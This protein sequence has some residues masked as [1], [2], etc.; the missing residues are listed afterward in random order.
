MTYQFH[1]DIQPFPTSSG[2]CLNSNSILLLSLFGSLLIFSKHLLLASISKLSVFVPSNLLYHQHGIHTRS[3][4][5]RSGSKHPPGQRRKH[6]RNLPPRNHPSLPDDGKKICLRLQTWVN[7]LKESLKT[8]AEQ[9]GRVQKILESFVKVGTLNNLHDT[10]SVQN[11]KSALAVLSNGGGELFK[12]C[13][14]DRWK[15]KIS[16]LSRPAKTDFERITNARKLIIHS[17]PFVQYLGLHLNPP[18]HL[19]RRNQNFHRCITSPHSIS[20][21]YQSP[22]QS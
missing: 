15:D 10:P 19:R 18:H 3:P 9:R 8:L 12:P 4:F 13:S 16:Q 5:N 20:C 1:I 11:L 21:H 17:V 2:H 7:V 6:S 22:S 14:E